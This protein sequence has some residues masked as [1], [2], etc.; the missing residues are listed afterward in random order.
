M[1]FTTRTLQET[2]S[3]DTEAITKAAEQLEIARQALLRAAHY[4][5]DSPTR[6]LH[7]DVLNQKG[8]ADKVS[9]RLTEFAG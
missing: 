4:L 9:I 3:P 5:D 2:P 8:L 6:R 1:N 7:L